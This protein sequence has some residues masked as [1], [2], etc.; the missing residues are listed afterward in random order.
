MI[1]AQL[2]FENNTFIINNEHFKSKIWTDQLIKLLKNSRFHIEF[3]SKLFIMTKH[4]LK[5]KS[6]S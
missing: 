3:Y 1:I 6:S 2:C 5:M 4:G